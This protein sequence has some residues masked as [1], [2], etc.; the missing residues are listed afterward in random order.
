MAIEASKSPC[1]LSDCSV[2]ASN[3]AIVASKSRC[4]LTYSSIEASNVAI[5]VS[6]SRC[7]LRNSPGEASNVAIGEQVSFS[8]AKPPTSPALLIEGSDAEHGA[9]TRALMPRHSER[10]AKST[11]LFAGKNGGP[12]GT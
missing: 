8:F 3:L 5:E 4:S 12:F 1:S 2:E 11:A 7:S 6:K 10:D 9:P